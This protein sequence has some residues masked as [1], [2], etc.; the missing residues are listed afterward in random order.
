VVSRP[1]DTNQNWHIDGVHLDKEVHQTADRLIIFC[2][3]T[4]LN[5]A[6]GA[7]EFV[8]KSH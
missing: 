2:P 8:P 6:T 7:T 3:L 4:D 5:A 1:G